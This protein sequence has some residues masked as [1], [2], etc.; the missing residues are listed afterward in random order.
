VGASQRL[1]DVASAPAA[2][3]VAAAARARADLV[4]AAEQCDR[5]GM[6]LFTRRARLRLRLEG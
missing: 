5:L 4:E 6:P 2:V 1:A 3:L